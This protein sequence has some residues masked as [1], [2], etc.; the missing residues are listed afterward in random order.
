VVVAPEATVHI[1][2]LAA[3]G[4]LVW[5]PRE[6]A[7]SDVL[8]AWLVVAAAD[9]PRVNARAA[10]EASRRRVWSVRADDAGSSAARTPA[11]AVVDGVVVSVGS[12]DPRR[13]T[14]VRDAI[15]ADLVEGRLPTRPRRPRASGSV[16][17]IGGGPGDPGLITVRGRQALL[18]ADVVV[19][20]RLGPVALL[21]ELDADVEVIDAGKSPGRHALTQGQINEVIVSRAAAGLRVARL[22][23]G[24]P[25]VLGRGSEEVLA[26]REAG[27][28]VEVIPGITSAV[29]GPA[30][31]GIPVTHRGV[32]TGFVVVS[33]HVIEDLAPVARSGLTVVVLMGIA[34]LPRLADEFARAGRPA[35]TPVA[36]VH[37]AFDPHQR[38]VIGTLADIVQ[39]VAASGVANPSVIVIGDVVGV[40]PMLDEQVLAS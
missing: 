20:D 17:L 3:E 6:F 9:A 18:T 32:S 40:I 24:D 13:S 36:V 35:S 14:A 30:A 38:V 8:G 28:P 5:R 21:H 29:A 2:A 12:G 10:E 37:R 1:V 31:A 34:T 19:H 16:V 22:K 15:H 25:F 7:L 23:G 11:V 33:G 26:C 4:R 27:V 39:K